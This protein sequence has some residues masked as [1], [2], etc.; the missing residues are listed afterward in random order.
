MRMVDHK[1]VLRR[2]LIL[3]IPFLILFPKDGFA[4]P[5]IKQKLPIPSQEERLR[6]ALRLLR[7]SLDRIRPTPL[8]TNT[9][10]EVI[11]GVSNRSDT[12]ARV[13]VGLFLNGEF[14]GQ[15]HIIFVRPNS[16]AQGRVTFTS[17][18]REGNYTLELKAFPYQVNIPTATEGDV[19]IRIRS[20]LAILRPAGAADERPAGPETITLVLQN[21]LT[22]SVSNEGDTGSWLQVG[23]CGMRL[24]ARG[25]LSF[26]LSKTEILAELLRRGHRCSNFEVRSGTL[27]VEEYQILS[28]V[29]G[30]YDPWYKKV[31]DFFFGTVDTE[32]KRPIARSCSDPVVAGWH[33]RIGNIL[34]DYLIGYDTFAAGIYDGPMVSN[35]RTFQSACRVHS[36]TNLEAYVR[37]QLELNKNKIQFRIRFADEH[38]E[39][40]PAWTYVYSVFFRN[41][42]LTLTV[43]PG[44]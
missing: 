18:E 27:E 10:A 2:S 12:E 33:S 40:D 23:N 30:E 38:V 3:L 7:L 31:W 1:S 22:G 44:S 8:R 25:F 37:N 41:P 13:K 14:K 20:V 34:I 39:G 17:P 5:P 16:S 21:H 19:L 35:I 32:G 26:R 43:A 4:P 28:F 15:T 36:F 9:D 29:P 6:D 24:T 42:K 11:C